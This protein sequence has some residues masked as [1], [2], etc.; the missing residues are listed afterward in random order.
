MVI[1]SLIVTIMSLKLQ[2]FVFIRLKLFQ[3]HGFQMRTQ[4]VKNGVDPEHGKVC[5][6]LRRMRKGGERERER[7]REC[8]RERSR[9]CW[10]ERAR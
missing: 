6:D 10:R 7:S 4:E 8:W 5:L 1:L 2:I 3:L 9:E